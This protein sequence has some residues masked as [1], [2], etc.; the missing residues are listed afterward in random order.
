MYHRKNP[1][2]HIMSSLMFAIL[3]HTDPT[4]VHLSCKQFCTLDC[5]QLNIHSA[6]YLLQT[7]LVNRSKY[8][9]SDVFAVNDIPL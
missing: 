5:L 2:K 1:F 6:N 7:E 8:D 3:L 4:A 9:S